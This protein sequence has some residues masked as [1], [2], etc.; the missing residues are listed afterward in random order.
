MDG[1][2]M[3][4]RGKVFVI[5]DELNIRSTVKEALEEE[6]HEVVCYESPVRALEAMEQASPDLIVTDLVMPEMDGLELIK[7]TKTIDP[8]VNVVVITGDA[9]LESAIGAIRTGASDYLVKPFKIADLLGVVKKALNQKGFTPEVAVRHKAFP[10]RYQLK[11][12]I[13]TTPE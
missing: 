12:L 2:D 11:N 8:E 3:M 9:S 4:N 13:G 5:D 1:I 10:E 6:G 7:R